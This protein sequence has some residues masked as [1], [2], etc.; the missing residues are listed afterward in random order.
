MKL[1][2]TNDRIT[3]AAD[4]LAPLLDLDVDDMRKRMRA[5]DVA[6][7]SETGEGEDA[8][9]FRVT[10]RLDGQQV[11]LTCDADGNVIKTT[12]VRVAP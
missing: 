3:V 11:R 8:G 2:L 6:I 5:G 4:L 7:R 10:F 9:K 1:E 12:R